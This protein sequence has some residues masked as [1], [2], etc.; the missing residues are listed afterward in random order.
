MH[1]ES[2]PWLLGEKA[3]K[4]RKD[5]PTKG[6]PC[7]FESDEAPVVIEELCS[8]CVVFNSDISGRYAFDFYAFCPGV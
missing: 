1:D 8:F 6:I 5:S 4:F 2:A 7:K 3:E